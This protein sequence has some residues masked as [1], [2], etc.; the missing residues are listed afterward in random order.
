MTHQQALD[1]LGTRLCLLLCIFNHIESH[2]KQ[3][4]D[5]FDFGTIPFTAL[6]SRA[7]L[8]QAPQTGISST[9]GPAAAVGAVVDA[10]GQVASACEVR[11][12]YNRNS[13]VTLRRRHRV[14]FYGHAQTSRRL[15]QGHVF[16]GYLRYVHVHTRWFWCKD[17]ETLLVTCRS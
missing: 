4:H 8:P 1:S 17:L 6:T 11:V 16:V 7:P 14:S 2:I 5:D 13:N 3:A 15:R 10:A 12:R 9:A